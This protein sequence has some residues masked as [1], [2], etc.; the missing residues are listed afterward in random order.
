M[1]TTQNNLWKEAVQPHCFLD[2]GIQFREI[3]GNSQH[4]TIMIEHIPAA[5]PSPNGTYCIF[6][7]HF[8]EFPA[9][10]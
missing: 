8:I 3:R 6:S 4:S 7:S 1:R 9:S 10:F 2:R 5:I